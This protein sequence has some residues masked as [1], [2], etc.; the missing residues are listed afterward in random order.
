MSNLTVLNLPLI[1]LKLIERKVSVDHR[2][3]FARVFCADEL[4]QAGWINPIA[5]INSSYTGRKSTV[6]GLHYQ[7]PPFSEMKLVSCL[8]G[9]V[10]DVVVDIRKGSPT[11]LQWHAEVLSADNRR[12]LLIPEGFAH[13]FQ[14]LTDDVALLYCHSAAYESR[15]ERGLNPIDPRLDIQWPIGVANLSSR[16]SE[17]SLLGENFEGVCI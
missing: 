9:E 12:S 13:G 5:Q 10:W 11:F 3:K 17:C 15:A 7:G 2:G 8:L 1:G 6:R 16:D 14:T 4:L